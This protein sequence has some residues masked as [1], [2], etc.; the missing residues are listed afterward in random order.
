MGEG[1]VVVVVA[2]AGGAKNDEDVLR[3]IRL[4]VIGTSSPQMCHTVHGPRQV[5]A[6]RQSDGG[7]GGG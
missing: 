3:R 4:R 6:H 5:Q 2:L 7:G 1:V